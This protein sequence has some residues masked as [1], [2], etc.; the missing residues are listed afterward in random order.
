MF[1]DKRSYGSKPST[2]HITLRGVD[3]K[4]GEFFTYESGLDC[5]DSA[6]GVLLESKN[7]TWNLGRMVDRRYRH[8]GREKHPVD[9][10]YAFIGLATYDPDLGIQSRPASTSKPDL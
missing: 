5:R 6:T 4:T 2:K 9:L 7:I 3:A 10:A 1:R 8:G